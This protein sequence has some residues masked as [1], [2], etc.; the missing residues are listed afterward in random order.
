MKLTANTNNKFQ[1]RHTAPRVNL[2]HSK[3]TIILKTHNS[4]AWIDILESIDQ[5]RDGQ[6]HASMHVGLCYVEKQ[7]NSMDENRLDFLLH[8]CPISLFVMNS[9]S[10]V[11]RTP[12]CVRVGAVKGNSLEGKVPFCSL[13]VSQVVISKDHDILPVSSTIFRNK[14]QISSSSILLSGTRTKLVTNCETIFAKKKKVVTKSREHS[15]CKNF[16]KGDFSE[17]IHIHCGIQITSHN[18]L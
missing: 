11:Q 10:P 13:D 5:R 4:S 7:G 6:V 14:Q 3:L 15:M 1:L 12:A 18:E 8:K 2:P 17:I 9:S 16:S